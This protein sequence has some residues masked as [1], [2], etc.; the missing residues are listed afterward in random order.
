MRVPIRQQVERAR[1]G[2]HER[3]IC[4]LP[5]GLLCLGSYQFLPGYCVLIA[6]PIVESINVL[7]DA[8]RAQFLDDMTRVGDALFKVS[9]A[10]RINYSLLGNGDPTLH[11]HIQPRYL[12]EDEALR[13]GPVD[14]YDPERI[15]SVPF[16]LERDRPLM[17][18][19]RHE[20]ERTGVC[21]S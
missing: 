20:L 11:A 9:R 13:R 2:E 6:D 12:S 18:D 16:D 8:A 14:K 19:I 4:R 1:R 3:L 10:W 7:P 21:G 15:A 5:S 17:I